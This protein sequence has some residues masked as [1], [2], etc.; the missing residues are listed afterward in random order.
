MTTYQAVLA[1]GGLFFVA[2]AGTILLLPR[3]MPIRMVVLRLS[4]GIIFFLLGIIGSLLPILQGW[5]F[6]LIAF[7]L[8]F[9]Q[10]RWTRKLLHKAEPKA[11][12]T[13]AFLRRLGIG[14]E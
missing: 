14:V 8:F 6:F 1:G 11:P 7:L 5:V 9:P 12:R 10:N 2:I 4:L 3:T 13:V